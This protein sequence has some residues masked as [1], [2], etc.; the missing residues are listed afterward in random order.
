MNKTKILFATKMRGFFKHLL[1]VES[2]KLV[3]Y[4]ETKNTKFYEKNSQ[5]KLVLKKIIAGK[6][7]D[8]LGVVQCIHKTNQECDIMMSYNRFMKTNKPYF[9]V[10][11]NPTAVYHYCLD[12]G[13]SVLG[14]KT[15]Q[16]HLRNENLK[17]IVCISDA[18]YSTVNKLIEGIPENIAIKRIYPL[19]PK[20]S[21]LEKINLIDR[22]FREELKCLYI[23]SN[24]ELKSGLELI[25]VFDK[26]N[27][28]NR[29]S[30]R[31]HII[32]EIS[33]LD[34]VIKKKIENNPLISLENFNLTYNE[35]E[36]RY[37]NA[38]I[39]LHLSRQD[40]FP[41][42][43]LE[44]LKAGLA[45]LSTN[46]YAIPEMVKNN[47]NGYLIRP[48]YLFFSEDNLPNRLVWNNRKNTIYS[49]YID[50]EIVEFVYSYL[51]ELD[52]NREK[53]S[54]FSKESLRISNEGEFNHEK[55]RCEWENFIDEIR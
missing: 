4:T 32:T 11:E 39:L 30:I 17:G 45:V 22:S 53:L 50:N 2:D 18:C 52:L 16:R 8:L 14:K 7:G 29:K 43:V 54:E 42:T 34:S 40:S 13:K 12:R 1:S 41:L 35:L 51:G 9:I 31:L 36:E 25:E 49:R 44:G 15:I 6:V 37:A 46:I 24:F 47:K 10:L 33:K 19:I 21:F 48:K 38:N 55:L 28:D 20:N 23:S 3:F 5:I 26:F 27:A